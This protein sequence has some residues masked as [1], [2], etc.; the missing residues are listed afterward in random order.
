MSLLSSADIFRWDTGQVIAGTQGI[1]PGP[2]VRL[3]NRHL[4]YANLKD[5]DLHGASFWSANLSFADLGG[6]NLANAF[7]DGATLASANLA[8]TDLAN[9]YINGSLASANLAGANLTNA[10]FQGAA[11]AN[12]NLAGA[13]LTG[14]RFD[15]RS[16]FTGANLAGAIVTGADFSVATAS[17]FT[18]EQLYSTASYQQK[19]LQGIGLSEYILGLAAQSNLAD[20]DFNHQN[21]TNAI[22]EKAML[23]R[24]NFTGANLTNASFY[25][26][27]MTDAN[28]AGAMVT[29]ADFSATIGFSKEQLYSTASY[30]QKNLQRIGLGGDGHLLGIQRD[31]TGW[32]FSGQDLTG[33]RLRLATLTDANLTGA[34][35]TGA[36]FEGTTSRGFT[37]EQLHSTASYQQK[38]LQGILL[39]DNDLT[40]WDLSGQDLTGAYFGGSRLTNTSL[41]G[42]MIARASFDGTTSRGFT[43]EQLYSTASYQQRNLQHTAF[44]SNDLSGWNFSGQ[45]LTGASFFYSTLASAD[46]A[47]ANVLGAGFY[48]TTSRGFT[49]EQLYSTASYE[50]SNLQG[51]ALGDN[52]LTGWNFRGQDLTGADLASANLTDANL[53]NANLTNAK[54]DFSSLTDADLS[55]AIVTGASFDHGYFGHSS[56]DIGSLTKEQL[57]STAS[58]QQKNLKGVRLLRN[59]LREWDLHNQDLSGVIFGIGGLEGGSDLT[60]ANFANANLTDASF[61]G[62]NLTGA[63][64]AGAI[65]IGAGFYGPILRGFTKEQ[66]YSTASYQQKNL[67]GISLGGNDLTGWDLS[68]QDL[69][70]GDVHLGTDAML[71]NAI[72]AFG[73]VDGLDLSG[74]EQL[75]VRNYRGSP[76]GDSIP[77]TIY[78]R[79]TMGEIGTL[80]AVLDD[81]EWGSTIAFQPGIPVTLGGTLELSFAPDVDLPSQVGRSIRLFNWSGVT[82]TGTFALKSQYMWDVSHVYT[83]GEV[84]LLAIPEPMSNIQ[85]IFSAVMAMTFVRNR[86]NCWTSQLHNGRLTARIKDGFDLHLAAV[87]AVRGVLF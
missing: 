55:G 21:L 37:K 66:L 8:G 74:G 38:S 42:A 78:H 22:F 56:D 24:A 62:T 18:K 10:T 70:G 41:A 33:A 69:R 77:I 82:P 30:Q 3:D 4:P 59:N 79:M 51:I 54:L 50:Q 26:A 67:Q 84:T 19:N 31:L 29:G 11:F 60:G 80:T 63:N 7:L 1:T 13:N 75:I 48:S 53:S 27:T 36:S 28:L 40:N 25:L 17:G 76:D 72:L 34:I 87:P 71:R 43:K 83:T 47:G 86:R 49:K 16:R 64:L 39:G 32:D 65:V 15:H 14:A 12:A 52:D 61:G 23:T 6:S 9:T 44:S 81:K 68:G 5:L 20:W 46:L 73:A 85:L 35:V 57:Y 2:G 45:D 58:Y